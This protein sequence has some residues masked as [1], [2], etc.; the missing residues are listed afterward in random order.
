[1]SKSKGTKPTEAELEVLQVLWKNGP[2]TVRFVHEKISK[3]KE[4]GYTTTLKIMQNMLDKDLVNRDDST[5]THVYTA[6]ANEEAT[7]KDLLNRFLDSTFGGSAMKL[8]M[9][10]LGNHKA[11]KEEI[12]KIR[13]L[14]KEKE[15]GSK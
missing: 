9:Q 4:I 8:V 12:S 15:G 6:V 7:Q 10:A 1:M 13:E 11:S 14:L 5:R 2:S 3:K